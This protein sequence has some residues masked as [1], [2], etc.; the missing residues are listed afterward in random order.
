MQKLLIL[1][2][3]LLVLAAGVWKFILADGFN[4]RFPDGWTWEINTLGTISYAD[5]ASGQFPEGSTPTDDPITLTERKITASSQGMPEGSVKLRD[6]F[7]TRDPA[8]NTVV[9]EYTYETVVDAKTGKYVDEAYADDYFLFPTNVEKEAYN[10]RNTSYQGIPAEFQG[11]EVVSDLTTY[12]FAYSQDLVNE[13]AYVG[14]VTLEEGQ[15]I[16]CYDFELR[17]WVEPKTGEVVKYR[18]WCPGD[19]VVDAAT[20]Q[21]LYGLQRWSGETTGDDLILRVDKVKDAIGRYNLYQLYLPILLL[22]AGT[23]SLLIGVSLNLFGTKA[24]TA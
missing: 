12:V 8:T 16:I 4:Q 18:E 14:T 3:I 15:T 7:V 5:E 21:K 17:Y 20:G 11:E 13:A 1:L 2:G 23:A 6:D 22:V 9:W 24:A 10:I 19:Y